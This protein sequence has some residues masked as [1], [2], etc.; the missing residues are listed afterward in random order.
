LDDF[1]PIH[2][3]G[4]ESMIRNCGKD[5]TWLFENLQCISMVPD[6]FEGMLNMCNDY[7]V[8]VLKGSAED[9]CASAG[10]WEPPYYPY[11]DFE[12]CDVYYNITCDA[13]SAL[14]NSG[15]RGGLWTAEEVAEAQNNYPVDLVNNRTDHCYTI[16][17]DWVYDFG[18]SPLDG[19]APFY[20]KHGNGW[21]PQAILKWC[22]LDMT[23][24]F[25]RTVDQDRECVPD[26]TRGGMNV[27]SG[28]VVGAIE[29]SNADPCF[30]EPPTPQ[31][32]LQ[33]KNLQHFSMNDVRN[34]QTGCPI[35][36]LG[37]VYNLEEFAIYHAGGR[38]KITVRACP[39]EYSFSFG[40]LVAN[41][42][43]KIA[44]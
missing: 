28:Y 37:K 7:I 5:A 24:A 16:L 1:I 9:P 25:D 11:P 31:E 29:G 20:L 23:Q 4:P 39:R 12:D 3:G 22:G 19:S 26:H 13:L 27:L 33:Q 40:A 32:V 17:H 10:N 14:P 15:P 36:V 6:H 41:T 43:H 38:S 44:S 30:S 18:V 35:V 8:G 21:Y 42:S 2:K 34:I